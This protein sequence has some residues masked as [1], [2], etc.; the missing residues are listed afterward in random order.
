MV[1]GEVTK[2]LSLTQNMST[3][4]TLKVQCGVRWISCAMPLL[5]SKSD[6]NQHLR[7]RRFPIMFLGI[8]FKLLTL[9]AQQ[10]QAYTLITKQQTQWLLLT[11]NFGS[12]TSLCMSKIYVYPH[13]NDCEPYSWFHDHGLVIEKLDLAGIIPWIPDGRHDKINVANHRK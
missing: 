10:I 5:E 3:A 11:F 12:I 7:A 2:P 4:E 13:C 6:Q 1:W 8:A 9:E